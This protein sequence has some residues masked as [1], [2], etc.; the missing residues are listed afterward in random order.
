VGDPFLQL[1]YMTLTSLLPFRA[2]ALKALDARI[3]SSSP[4]PPSTSPG[5]APSTGS[6]PSALPVP[7]ASQSGGAGST[8]ASTVTAA[9]AAPA[10]PQRGLSTKSV[11]QVEEDK[12]EK[13]KE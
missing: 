1:Q 10:A 8:A 13:A 2:L 7:A 5:A 4:A 3:A 9:P 6:V 12:S 11:T